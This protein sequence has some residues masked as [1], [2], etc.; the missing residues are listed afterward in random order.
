MVTSVGC[1][2]RSPLHT[3]DLLTQGI[4]KQHNMA[5]HCHRARLH[6]KIDEKSITYHFSTMRVA[7]CQPSSPTGLETTKRLVTYTKASSVVGGITNR[8]IRTRKAVLNKQSSTSIPLPHSE[9][10]QC[11]STKA[12][13]RLAA[14]Y[15]G[16]V[17]SVLR[18]TVGRGAGCAVTRCAGAR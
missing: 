1:L 2:H 12:E 18:G 15:R 13:D 5:K 17:G 6:V 4:P 7:S 16:G 9:D 11:S 10:G 14:E 3:S 8:R